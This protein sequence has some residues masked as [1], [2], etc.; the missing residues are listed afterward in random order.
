MFYYGTR[1]SAE[2]VRK[3]TLNYVRNSAF[4]K[5]LNKV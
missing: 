1:I 3:V 4:K 2:N 5:R